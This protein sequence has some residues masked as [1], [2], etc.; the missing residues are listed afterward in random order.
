MKNLYCVICGKNRKLKKPK[1]SHF[2]EKT[3]VLSIICKKFKIK[4][5]KYLKKKNQLKY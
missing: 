1:I 4:L 5:K 2:L 3:L